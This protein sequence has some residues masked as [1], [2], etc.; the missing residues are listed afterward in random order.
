MRNP[1]T[2]TNASVGHRKQSMDLCG[3]WRMESEG[4]DDEVNLNRETSFQRERESAIQSDI[5]D[6]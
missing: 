5:R 1:N 6:I 2:T 3:E 4:Y